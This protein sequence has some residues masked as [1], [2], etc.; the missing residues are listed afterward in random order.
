VSGVRRPWRRGGAPPPPG[1]DNQSNA[2]F[3]SRLASEIIGGGIAAPEA[4][5]A[6]RARLAEKPLELFVDSTEEMLKQFRG[7][8]VSQAQTG[9]KQVVSDVIRSFKG[10]YW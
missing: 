3:F 7:R 4:A 5:V 10:W 2:F 9:L 6:E 8:R 1:I